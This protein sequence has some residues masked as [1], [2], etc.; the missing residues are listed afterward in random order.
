MPRT[1]DRQVTRLLLVVDD[2]AEICE[3]VFE[4][5][6]PHGF[7]VLTATEGRDAVERFRQAADRIQAVLLD[8]VMPGMPGATVF[9]EIHRLRPDVPVI[10]LT[11][12]TERK[13]LESVAGL[14]VAGYILK[15]F[16]REPLLAKVRE[17]LGD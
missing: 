8:L 17:V 12:V 9:R 6:T 1:T 7:T 5:L 10:L 15:P 16:L 4:M 3:L 11:G 14:P 2:A 13:A